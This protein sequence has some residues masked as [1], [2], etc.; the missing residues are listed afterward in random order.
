MAARQVLSSCLPELLRAVG[1]AKFALQLAQVLQQQ[2]E[3][4]NCRLAQA[5]AQV[6]MVVQCQ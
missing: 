3:M 6:R 1:A 2:V 5:A 4:C